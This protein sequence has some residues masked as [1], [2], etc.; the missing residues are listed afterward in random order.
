MSLTPAILFG[1]KNTAPAVTQAVGVSGTG[2]SFFLNRM[3]K[4]TR[5]KDMGPLWRAVVFD[6]KHDGY[7][8][9]VEGEKKFGVCTTYAQFVKSIKDHKITVI[10]PEIAESY[11]FLDDVIEHLFG[12]ARRVEGFTATLV[13]EESNTYIGTHAS[14]IP[15]QI[16]RLATQGRSLG[17][18]LVLA[19]QRSLSNKWT[20]TQS[21]RMIVFRTAIPDHEMLKKKWGL[22][23]VEMDRKLSEKKFRFAEFD[24]ETLEVQYYEPLSI[25]DKKPFKGPTKSDN[26]AVVGTDGQG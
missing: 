12:L 26:V 6:I 24:L 19:N 5:V 8:D 7:A 11:D 18:S 1:S 20:D 9:L 25:E 14:A 16:K 4:A 21:Q 2:K 17:L 15:M 10:H 3:L 22:E 13:L 23:G